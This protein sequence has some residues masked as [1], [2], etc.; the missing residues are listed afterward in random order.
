MLAVTLPG[1]GGGCPPL[2]PVTAMGTLQRWHGEDVEPTGWG[3]PEGHRGQDKLRTGAKTWCPLHGWMVST[4]G[5]KFGRSRGLCRARLALFSLSDGACP[6]L[7]GFRGADGFTLHDVGGKE[8]FSSRDWG[9]NSSSRVGFTLGRGIGL[10]SV[11]L[12]QELPP[13]CGK[14]LKPGVVPAAK[15]SWMTRGAAMEELV[16]GCHPGPVR[17]G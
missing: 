15:G 6:P 3:H 14:G 2:C 1:C 10:E 7:Q 5:D 9:K 4:P 16:A 11:T 17:L 12:L 13:S 8:N